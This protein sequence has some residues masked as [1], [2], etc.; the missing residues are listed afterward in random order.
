M[1][2]R[3]R[4]AWPPG[5]RTQ[6]AL[7]YTGVFA[8]LFLLIGGAY[9]AYLQNLLQQSFASAL[10]A[11]TQLI[12]SGISLENGA[13]CIQDVAGLL[14]GLNAVAPCGQQDSPAP[15]AT[16]P[17]GSATGARQSGAQGVS[18]GDLV[19]ILDRLGR[20][21]YSSQAFGALAIPQ[22]SV[23]QPLQ[24]GPAWSGMVTARNGADVQLYSAP[25][26]DSTG[27]IYGVVQVGE[28]LAPLAETLQDIVLTLFAI[29]PFALLLSAAGSYW[30]AGRTFRPILRLTRTAREIE[31][32]DLHRRVPVPAA[33]DEVRDL[34]LTLNGMIARLERAFAQQRR[35]VADASHELRTPVA[36]IRS[37]TDVALAEAA[38]SREELIATMGDVNAEAERL[39]HLISDLLAL[40]RADESQAMLDSEP[41]RLD[42]LAAE[43][44]AVAEPLAAERGLTL[45]VLASEEVVVQGDETRL[46][47]VAMNLIDNAIRYTDR[48][49]R[50]VVRVM[51]HGGQ[52][53]LSIA[54]T[55]IGIAAEHLPLLFERFYRVD[56]ARLR[57]D[58]GSGLGLAIV[59]WV[60]RAHGGTVEVESEVGRGSS[61]TVTLPLAPTSSVPADARVATGLET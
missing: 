11:R 20:V 17:P 61:F 34:A 27:H 9:Y 31:A 37:M 12:S 55:G 14:P 33:R 21:V 2:G 57:A 32:E 54:D 60:V 7:L 25:L 58:A 4:R 13:V 56:P 48:G 36:A 3:M 30:L 15:S 10:A 19:R 42:I 45:E 28:P 41:V 59:D 46:T 40:A 5:I 22:T 1:I 29:A 35:F 23:Q 50:V 39:G 53:C 44:T 38:A 49:G 8:L 52:A 16:E 26:T 51:E 6:L 18:Y 24:G 43:A 47:Q